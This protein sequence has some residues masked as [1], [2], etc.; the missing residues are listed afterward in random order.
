MSE[1]I[2]VDDFR[3][4]PQDKFFLDTNIWMYLYCSIGNYNE[5]MVGKYNEFYEKILSSKARIYTNSLQ[6]SEFFNAYCRLEYNIAKGSNPRLHYKKDFRNSQE[7]KDTVAHLQRI[8]NNRIFKYATKLDDGFSTVDME[9]IFN[10]GDCFDFND[11]YFINMC[12]K[13]SILIVTND[14]D[15]IEHPSG[16]KVVS[17]L[18]V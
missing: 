5:D 1:I 17:N 12:L 7:F 13:D 3:P 14:R 11:E 4:S 10:S 6:I 8:V 9:Q 2:H 16:I 18:S 15:F